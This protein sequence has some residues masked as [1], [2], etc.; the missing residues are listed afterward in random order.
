M[1]LRRRTLRAIALAVGTTASVLAITA[2]AALAAA[3]PNLDRALEAQRRLSTDHPQDPAAWNDLGNLLLL[4]N[5]TSEAEA[6]Y[7]R[8]LQLD[9]KKVST[10]FNLGLLEQQQ[11]RQKDAMRYFE[12]AL[13]IDPHHAWSHFQIGLILER[14]GDRSK[15]IKSYAQAFSIDPQLALPEVNP[16]VVGSKLMTEA[17]LHAYQRGMASDPVRHQ[18]DDPQRIATLL[19]QGPAPAPQDSRAGVETGARKV[20]TPGN[21]RP[22]TN[23]GQAV[24]PGPQRPRS[25]MPSPGNANTGAYAPMGSA[26]GVPNQNW[27]RPQPSYNPPPQ[28]PGVVMPP[29]AGLYYPRPASTGQLSTSFVPEPG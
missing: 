19:V 17:L 22:G 12:Q 14:R 28:Q 10:L 23:V 20:L 1:N 15:A 16:Q 11:G 21:L 18:Y 2:L 3:P 26:P 29:P 13:Q 5:R 6:A 25:G 24:P 9:P 8:A 7:Q 4:A 27:T